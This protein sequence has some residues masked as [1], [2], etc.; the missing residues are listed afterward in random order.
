MSVMPLKFKSLLFWIH[1]WLGIAMCLL[2][3]LWFA[4]GVVMMYVEYPELTEAERLAQLPRL[5]LNR[6]SLTPFEASS[7]IDSASAFMS[8]KLTSVLDRPTFEYRGLDGQKFYVFADSGERI[9]GVGEEAA[10]QAATLSGLA[11]RD[12][13]PSY[14]ALIDMDQWSISASHNASRPLHRIDMND[15]DNLVLYV[16][17]RSGQVVLDT[18]GSER[19]WNWLGSTIHWI[20]PLQLRKNTALWTDVIVYTSLVGII[21]VVTGGIVGLIRIRVRN[22]YKGKN[23]SPYT[24]WMKWHHILGLLSLLFVSTFIFSGLMSMGP[25]GIFNSSTSVFPQM[26]RYYGSDTLRLSNLPMPQSGDVAPTLKEIEWHQI[27]GSYYFSLVDS[28]EGTKVR[29][30]DINDLN[31]STKLLALVSSAIPNL[32]PEAKL[33]SREVLD[34]EDTYYYSR[35]NNVRPFPVY[36][37]IFD[38]VESTWYH[39]NLSNGEVVNRITDASRLERWL[40]N[41]LH[42]LDFQFLLRH[43]PLWDVVMILLSLIGLVFSVTAIVIGWRRLVN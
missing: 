25:W 22:P 38:D 21:S 41:G 15:G 23:M 42:S 16:S 1:R 24:G 13:S 37:A 31:S 39:I 26:V 6:V 20:Y 28:E 7:A 10:L 34:E 12:S 9:S 3:A 8:V 27:Q 18:T 43:R 11:A 36:R 40:F 17:E 32:L 30:A 35:H 5:D 14:D 19:F 29:F 33:E 2:F 4:S